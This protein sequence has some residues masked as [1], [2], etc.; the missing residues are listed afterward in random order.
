MMAHLPCLFNNTQ[1]CLHRLSRKLFVRV[2]DL[3]DGKQPDQFDARELQML[4]G[5][6]QQ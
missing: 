1:D 2:V 5:G 3:P 6:T 4:L